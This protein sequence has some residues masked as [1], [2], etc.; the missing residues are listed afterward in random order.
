VRLSDLL[1]ITLESGNRKELP[2]SEEL[3]FIRKYLDIEKIRIGE[4]LTITMEID[5]KS[6]D[7]MVP[8][9]ILQPLVE[10]AIKYGVAPH[11]GTG[12]IDIRTSR[13]NGQMMLSV[14]DNGPGPVTAERV[15]PG[16]IGLT[17]TRARL[18]HHFGQHGRLYLDRRADGFTAQIT[19][20][21]RK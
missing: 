17:N 9:L 1:R 21:C 19:F 4:R 13:S 5:P 14:A 6:L 3:E 7:C 12:R 18:E 11:T 15:R 16:G 20:P 10:N 8:T 2:L